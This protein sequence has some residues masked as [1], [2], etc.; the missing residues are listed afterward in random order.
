MKH[1]HDNPNFPPL[2]VFVIYDP[3]TDAY[4]TSRVKYG[5]SGTYHL[6]YW[7]KDIQKAK[8]YHDK[9]EAINAAKAI[10]REGH[11]KVEVRMVDSHE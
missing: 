10:E 1:T 4:M 5:S 3:E 6:T 11:G 8:Y 2:V 9:R 7:A